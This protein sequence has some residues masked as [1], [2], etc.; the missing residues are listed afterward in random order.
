ME[1]K[2][3]RAEETR[4]E[5]W[6]GKEQGGAEERGPAVG[7]RWGLPKAYDVVLLPVLHLWG[8]R[9]PPGPLSGEEPKLVPL[10][11]SGNRPWQIQPHEPEGLIPFSL[12]SLPSLSPLFPFSL[13][14]AFTHSLPITL[15]LA[16]PYCLPLLT[17]ARLLVP[18]SILPLCLPH[19]L[20][21]PL[22]ASLMPSRS[23]SP[24]IPYLSSQN[25]SAFVSNSPWADH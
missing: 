25:S 2:G 5:D 11:L 4:R 17:A 10:D 19:S 6:G 3:D 22:S 7:V 23:P 9:H 24:L 13:P 15:S 1:E 8:G 16:V 12:S 20:P 18:L 21:A 14:T